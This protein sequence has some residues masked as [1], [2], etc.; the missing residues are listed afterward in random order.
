MVT[1]L[2]V[3]LGILVFAVGACMFSF[4][5]VVIYRVPRHMDFITGRSQCPGCGHMLNA[6]DMIPVLSWL[7][8][9][10]RCRYCRAAISWRYMAVEILGGATA[11]LT[12]FYQG[13]TLRALI[14]FS[15]FSV[16][17]AVAFVDWDTME[18]P[19]GFIAAVFI[20][21]VLDLLIQGEF[22]WL[23]NLI[24]AAAVSIPMFLITLL[25]PNAFGGGDIKLMAVCGLFLG[26]KLILVSFFFSVIGG[27]IYGAYLLA[28]KKMGRKDHFP[29][30][31]FLCAGMFI[32]ALWGQNL[33][34]W[35]LGFFI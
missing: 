4:L 21:A 32:A 23:G 14:M 7:L 11:L 22:P 20:V 13:F 19:D 28:S 3:L 17:A 30:G 8:L 18:I 33:L 26:W 24:G 10:G 1:S 5:N 27:G 12:V 15:F 34:E 29:F 9:R 31:P 25:I 6:L 35:Y 16:L 2:Q